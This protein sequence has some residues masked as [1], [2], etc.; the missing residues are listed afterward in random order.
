MQSTDAD[1]EHLPRYGG[2]WE[3]VSG[4]HV[5]VRLI[6]GQEHGAVQTQ[7]AMHAP[8]Q[9]IQSTQNVLHACKLVRCEFTDIRTDK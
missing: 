9:N 3:A 8:T 2:E 1:P 5:P 6:A 4:S 7:Q